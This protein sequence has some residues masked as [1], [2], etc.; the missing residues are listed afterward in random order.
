MRPVLKIEGEVW[1]EKVAGRPNRFVVLTE[2]GRPCHLHDPGRLKEL[3]YPGNRILVRESVGKKTDCSVLAAW[4][5]LWVVVDSRFHNPIA[6]TF[7]PDNVEAEVRIGKSRIDFRVKDIYVEVKGCSLVRDGVALFPDA[8]TT[9]GEKHL[10]ELI[11][12]MREGFRALLMVLVMR[13]DAKCFLP[14][15]VTDPKFSRTFWK[16][17]DAGMKLRVMTFSLIGKEIFYV[18]DIGLCQEVR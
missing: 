16:A 5:G 1:E 7:L 13:P 8:P 14:N 18:Q 12:V 9:R 4:N 15:E 11:E 10:R 3:I 17:L 6:R 2:G